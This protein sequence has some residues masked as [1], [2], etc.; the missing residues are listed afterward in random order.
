MPTEFYVALFSLVGLLLTGAATML[1]KAL[2][3]GQE[4]PQVTAGSAAA[5]AMG[6]PPPPQV[7]PQRAPLQSNADGSGPWQA[8]GYPSWTSPAQVVAPIDRL[9]DRTLVE[10]LAPISQM[11]TNMGAELSQRITGTEDRLSTRM[12]RHHSETDS[13]L[14]TLEHRLTV[15]ETKVDERTRRN[16]PPRPTRLG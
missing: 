15:L 12:D 10:S 6:N 9:T 3:G 16:S 14:E 2:R 1:A 8:Q 5:H 13:K 7:P 4:P 11:I